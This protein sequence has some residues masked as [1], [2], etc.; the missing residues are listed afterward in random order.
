[1]KKDV[2]RKCERKMKVNRL[3]S[4]IPKNVVEFLKF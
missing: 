4:I 3:N 1:M 2:E